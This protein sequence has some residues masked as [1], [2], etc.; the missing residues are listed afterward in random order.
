MLSRFW[1]I[2]DVMA[3]TPSR[4]M[5]GCRFSYSSRYSYSPEESDDNAAW[6]RLGTCNLFILFC[7]LLRLFFH[8]LCFWGLFAG[9]VSFF[10]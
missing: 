10:W 5:W 2:Q 1:R 3:S 8:Y 7:V 6:E 4:Y 9:S